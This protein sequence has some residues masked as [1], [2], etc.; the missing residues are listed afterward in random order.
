[1]SEAHSV[2][3]Y[4]A[5]MSQSLYDQGKAVGRMIEASQHTIDATKEKVTDNALK[6]VQ[7]STLAK[8]AMVDIGTKLSIYA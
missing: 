4:S 2:G 7:K 8:Q 6:E 1:M 5:A 3:S